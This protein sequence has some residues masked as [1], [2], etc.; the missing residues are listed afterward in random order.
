MWIM[1]VLMLVI[2]AIMWST[3]NEQVPLPGSKGDDR[4]KA[5]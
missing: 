5:Q 1:C 4:L 3:P 2:I